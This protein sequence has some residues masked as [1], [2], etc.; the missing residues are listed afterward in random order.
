[1][2]PS[3]LVAPLQLHLERV[4]Q[5]HRQDLLEGYSNANLPHA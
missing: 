3:K 1:M 2:L 4:K 5:L